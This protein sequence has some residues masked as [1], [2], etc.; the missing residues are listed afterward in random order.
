MVDIL[1][2]NINQRVAESQRQNHTGTYN[3]V[4]MDLTITVLCEENF[5]G[6]DCTQCVPGFIGANC[7]ER[8]HCFGV[9]CSGRGHCR[10]NF[11][12]NSELFTCICDN[13]YKGRFC[14]NIDCSAN[15]CNENG[16]CVD[17]I[18]LPSCNCN[19]G[20]TGRE[21]EIN[22][23]DCSSN[24]C[25]ERGQCVDGVNSFRCNCDPGF[26][27]DHCQT[28]IND[29]AGVMCS[30]NGAC[31]DGLNS[32]TCSCSCDL[33][34]TRQLCEININDCVGVNCIVEIDRVNSFTC[35]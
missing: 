8:D 35:A 25:G 14:G 1:F 21:C 12:I 31:V 27:G 15:N 16:I 11:M 6:S 32:F 9:N 7:D 22:I 28:N 34:F 24:P 17:D 29:C 20:F 33:G 23:D 2:V 13:G 10:N 5:G 3:L 4:T 19:L 30:G 26:T 18:S